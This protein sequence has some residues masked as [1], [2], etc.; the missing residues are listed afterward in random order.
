LLLRNG[1]EPREFVEALV[2]DKQYTTGIDFI[3]HLLPARQAIWWGCLCLQHACGDLLSP[4]E[5]AACRAAVQWVLRPTEE[6][7]VAAKAPADRAGP[8]NP[9]G[10]LAAAANQTGGSITPANAPRMS[11][12]PFAPA[13]AVAT[14]VKLASTK[15]DPIK[16][17]DRH[18]LFVR[19]GI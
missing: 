3:A 4:T 17:A 5:K 7:R 6:V 13:K 19:L 11:P 9:A 10:A 12:G 15:G 1:I 2:A 8:A 16:M 18:E 14:A